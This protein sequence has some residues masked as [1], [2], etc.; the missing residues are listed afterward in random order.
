MCFILM[1]CPVAL[2]FLGIWPFG[3]IELIITRRN[4]LKQKFDMQ[5]HLTR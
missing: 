2:P 5:Q 1:D 4:F 3:E